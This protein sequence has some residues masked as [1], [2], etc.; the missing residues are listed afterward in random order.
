MKRVIR[1]LFICI[2]LLFLAGCQEAP[3]EESYTQCQLVPGTLETGVLRAQPGNY[4]ERQCIFLSSDFAE[5]E[6]GY[7]RIFDN[8][9]YYADK[10]DLDNWVLV[11]PDPDCSHQITENC[12]AEN[13]SGLYIQDDRLYVLRET[14]Q[15]AHLY[16]NGSTLGGSVLCS[17]ALNGS[18][19]RL[20]YAYEDALLSDG[21]S[22]CWYFL[23]DGIIASV[24]GMDT[25]GNQTANMWYIDQ[26]GPRKI[27]EKPYHDPISVSTHPNLT[28]YG[29]RG[30]ANFETYM[31]DGY[32][33]WFCWFHEGQLQITDLHSMPFYRNSYLSGSTLRGFISNDGYYDYDLLTGEKVKLA[34]ARLENSSASVMQP[35]CIFESTLFFNFDPEIEAAAE[36]TGT[37]RLCFFDGSQW[38]DVTLPEDILSMTPS[39]NLAINGLFTDRVLFSVNQGNGIYLL[40][41]M[42]LDGEDYALQ[43]CGS[44]SDPTYGF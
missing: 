18:D 3:A 36:Q 35:N 19:L 39:A 28:T 22:C 15:V 1:L 27:M 7:Y 32:P 13:L 12:S 42:R 5:I 11:C 37:H 29:I 4:P 17:M 38:H 40:Y 23:G 14:R 8:Q 44:F 6:A 34:D 9:L 30:D 31:I 25:D 43:V 26:N 33:N 16:P 24:I 2:G 10:T 41:E 20:E 21:G